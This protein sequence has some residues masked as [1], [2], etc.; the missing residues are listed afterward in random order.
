MLKI[1]KIGGLLRVIGN[2]IMRRDESDFMQSVLAMVRDDKFPAEAVVTLTSDADEAPAP[3]EVP[4][5]KPVAE[6]TIHDLLSLSGSPITPCLNCGTPKK[7]SAWQIR[8][9]N[10]KVFCCRTCFTEYKYGLNRTRVY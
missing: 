9:N 3:Q 6:G 4:V 7:Q 10:G 1:E 2:S 5:T 8:R